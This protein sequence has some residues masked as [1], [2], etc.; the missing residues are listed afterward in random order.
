[1]LR[2]TPLDKIDYSSVSFEILVNIERFA[3]VLDELF[4]FF[5]REGHQA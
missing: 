4:G 5:E 2:S 3:A 1:V